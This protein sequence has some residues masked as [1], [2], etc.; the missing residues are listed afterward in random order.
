MSKSGIVLCWATNGPLVA[1]SMSRCVKATRILVFLLLYHCIPCSCRHYN[2]RTTGISQKR[3]YVTGV[4]ALAC[5]R[6]CHSKSNTL[7]AGTKR[8]RRRASLVIF[9]S[10]FLFKWFNR[11]CK[12]VSKKRTPSVDNRSQRKR[13]SSWNYW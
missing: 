2:T 10:A 5:R 8:G 11:G 13:R 12:Q 9:I 1:F 7:G 4:A 3:H 6:V